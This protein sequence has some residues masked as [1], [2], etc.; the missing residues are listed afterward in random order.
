MALR[1]AGSDKKKILAKYEELVHGS[2]NNHLTHYNYAVELYNYTFKQATRP[3]DFSK[4]HLKIPELLKKAIAMQSTV[5]ANLLLSRYHLVLINDLIDS[6]NAIHENTAE[7]QKKKDALNM[8]INKRYEEVL[9]AASSAYAILDSR[10]SLEAGDKE[11]FITAARMLSDYWERKN[12]R[13][14]Q[15]IYLDKVKELE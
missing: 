14:K 9:S 12:D 3:T 4:L 1:D 13:A 10:T 6:Y 11:N 15:K 5:E 2:C 7:K 8:E